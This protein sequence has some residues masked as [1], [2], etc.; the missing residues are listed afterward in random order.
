MIWPLAANIGD[1]KH[2]ALLS[3]YR[4]HPLHDKSRQRRFLRAG[5]HSSVPQVAT[6]CD[7][8]SRAKIV[9]APGVMQFSRVS[10]WHAPAGKVSAIQ[11][12]FYDRPLWRN[13]RLA[14]RYIGGA[15]HFSFGSKAIV[16]T[17]ANGRG[18]SGP[19]F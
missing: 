16:Q 7:I 10:L 6:C 17:D 4:A 1:A 18:I 15:S 9:R 5:L 14:E 3:A 11:M 19:E 8:S 2:P 13:F 12:P